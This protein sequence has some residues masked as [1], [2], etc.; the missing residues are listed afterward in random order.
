MKDFFRAVKLFAVYGQFGFSLVVPPVAM[1]LL[2]W[3]LQKKFDLG[4][5]ITAICL[6]LG[7]VTAVAVARQFYRKVMAS[8]KRQEQKSSVTFTHH[9]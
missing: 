2:G 7:V 4:G 6:L 1:G 3:W 5:W 8:E 9:D